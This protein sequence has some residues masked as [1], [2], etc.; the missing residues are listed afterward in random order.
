MYM[1]IYLHM[2]ILYVY[3]DIISAMHELQ[4]SA[5]EKELEEMRHRAAKFEEEAE[6]Q[7]QGMDLQLMDSQVCGVI[8]G[9]VHKQHNHDSMLILG[10]WCGAGG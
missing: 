5:L 3:M 7:S 4:I 8:K 1:Y 10:S 9:S 6:E 2:H